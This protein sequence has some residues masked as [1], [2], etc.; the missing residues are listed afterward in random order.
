MFAGKKKV[1]FSRRMGGIGS[2]QLLFGQHV[3]S[4]GEYVFGQTHFSI[5]LGTCE[6]NLRVLTSKMGGK[7]MFLVSPGH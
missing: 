6:S 3:A 2:K 7:N 4:F 1:Q 5:H